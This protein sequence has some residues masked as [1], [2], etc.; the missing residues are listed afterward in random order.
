MDIRVTDDRMYEIRS[1]LP[2]WLHK[3]SATKRELQSL[4]GKLQFVGKCVKLSRI[5]ISIILV[6]LRGLKHFNHKVIHDQYL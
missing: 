5:F 2:K 4:I 3:K 6:F 1:I